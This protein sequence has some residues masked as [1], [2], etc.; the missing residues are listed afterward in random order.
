MSLMVS[1]EKRKA[2]VAGPTVAAT[3]KAGTY[4]LAIATFTST[5]KNISR[6]RLC[7]ID[8]KSCGD[9]IVHLLPVG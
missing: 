1:R 9:G 6:F 2:D 3:W 8:M 7:V 5:L 4:H